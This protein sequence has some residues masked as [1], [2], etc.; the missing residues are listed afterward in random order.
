MRTQQVIEHLKQIVKLGQI[1]TDPEDL[2]V[3]SFEQIYRERFIF[4]VDAV[5]KTESPEEIEKIASLARENGFIVARRGN[6]SDLE[7][8]SGP[9]VLLDDSKTPNLTPLEKPE[10]T[11]IRDAKAFHETE[12]GT[13]KK[14]GLAQKLLFLGKVT[15]KCQECN[16][17]SSYCTVASHFNGNETW[18]AK[19]RLLLIKGLSRGELSISPKIVDIL[20]TCSNCGLCFAECLPYSELHE[21]IRAARQQITREGFG[22]HIF[23][24]T[25]ENI[26]K[27]G[28]PGGASSQKRLSVLKIS[29]NSHFKKEASVLYWVGCTVATRTPNTP[30]AVANIL[31]FAKVDFTSLGAEEGCC[32]YVLLAS[33]LWNDA[34]K[35]ANKLIEEVIETGASLIVTSCAGCYYTFSKLFPE[36]LGIEMPCDVLHTSQFMEKL[37]K[38]GRLNFESFDE[39]VTYHDPCSLGRHSNVYDAPRNV[40]N[41]IPRLDF[42]EMALSRSRSRCCGGGGGLWSYNNRVSIESASNRLVKDVAPLNVNI[43]ATSCPTCQMNLRYA[44]I[45][46]SISV[47]ICDFAE[48]IESAIV[49]TGY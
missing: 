46:N 10:K 34:K 28:D 33:G 19:G 13:L 16:L 42:V 11:S 17:C 29:S 7:E 45:R 48:I 22:P 35:N 31:N 5:V 2:Y 4:K 25:A 47:R 36:I 24:S 6:T 15:T 40:L 21:A 49:R 12:S 3:Y 18:S 26:L 41:E 20:Y 43:L 37:M 8:A 30:R 32:G 23:K 27:V 44:S 39:R 38:E 14:L 1:L 9:I